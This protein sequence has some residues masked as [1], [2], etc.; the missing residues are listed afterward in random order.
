MICV[1]RNITITRGRVEKTLTLQSLSDSRIIIRIII[2]II[3]M[4]PM[5]FYVDTDI[6]RETESLFLPSIRYIA[7]T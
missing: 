3:I 2:I 6:E 5:Y 7:E 4:N 1:N